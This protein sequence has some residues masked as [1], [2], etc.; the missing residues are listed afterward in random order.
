MAGEDLA[1]DLSL[2]FHCGCLPMPAVQTGFHRGKG[3]DLNYE[4]GKLVTPLGYVGSG[5][6]LP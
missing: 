3:I 5:A 1:Q 2:G 4:L 6:K